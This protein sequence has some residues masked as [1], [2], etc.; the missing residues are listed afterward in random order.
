MK[1]LVIGIAAVA[2]LA[3]LAVP[4]MAFVPPV[5]ETV[6]VKI[7]VLAY[8]AIE[9]SPAELEFDVAGPADQP[10]V[11]GFPYGETLS[12]KVICNC[13]TSLVATVPPGETSLCRAAPGLPGT[14]YYPH[15]VNGT[16]KIGFGLA[17]ENLT[18]GAYGPWDKLKDGKAEVSFGA[19]PV[20]PVIDSNASITVNSYMDSARGDDALAPP[21]LYEQTVTLTLSE[22][23]PPP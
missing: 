18:T 7:N 23:T 16:H 9:F 3:L 17:L 19:S 8:G 4:V 5:E 21:G 20:Y 14:D 15:A 13:L 10:D 11:S 2:L 1:K 6:Y 22:K 12:F